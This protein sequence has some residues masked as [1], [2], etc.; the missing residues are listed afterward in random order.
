MPPELRKKHSDLLALCES[1]QTQLKS[2]ELE[3]TA[4]QELRNQLS[5]AA[6]EFDTVTAEI[7]QY[8]Q[9]QEEEN[10][11]LFRVGAYSTLDNAVT[12]TNGPVIQHIKD[13]IHD[14]PKLGF[15]NMGD[16]GMAA[17]NAASPNG[18]YDKRLDVL[19]AIDGL[20]QK[21][22]SK[23]GFLVPP[24]FRNEIWTGA[25]QSSL[26]TWALTDNFTFPG[27]SLSVPAVDETS[28]KTGSRWGGTQSYWADEAATMT[29][30]DPSFREVTII[31]KELHVFT[32]VTN[33][34][35]RNTRALGQ[36]LN[37]SST[38]EIV[39]NLSDKL[40]HGTGAGQPKG[41][42][43]SGALVTEAKE[44]AQSADTVLPANINKMYS[45][46]PNRW[47]NGAVWYIHRTVVPQLESMTTGDMPVYLPPNGL[48]GRPLGTLKGSPVVVT[49]YNLP[50]GDVGDIIFTNLQ[51]YFSG[52]NGG[53][54]SDTSIH[55]YFDTNQTAFRWILNADGCPYMQNSIEEYQGTERISPFVTLAERA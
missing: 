1:L 38:D 53:L 42:L 52:Q 9:E 10:Q 2:D 23:G 45:R 49:E 28:R 16:L 7:K 41:I 44:S 14:D 5:T 22:P 11:L 18:V 32:R 30:S 24:S 4:R 43:N 3:T 27:E 19:G 34:L 47:L 21:L 25:E 8:E 37:K 48:A 26:N 36:F 31:P 20:N 54:E 50:V 51:A 46:M 6:D 17:F 40:F 12:T 29:E 39:F 35:L 33:K 55:F 13:N 15:Q